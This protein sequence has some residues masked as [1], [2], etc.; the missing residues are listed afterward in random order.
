MLGER[1]VDVLAWEDFGQRW[2]ADIV[3]ELKP[4]DTRVLTADYGHLPDLASRRLR[5]RR[6]LHLERH[7]SGRARAGRQLDCRRPPRSHLR[8]CHV[9]AVRAG[10]RLAQNRCRHVL[11][12]EGARRGSGA[13]HDRPVAARLR[14]SRKVIDRAGRCPSSSVSPRTAACSTTFSPGHHQHAVVAV[15][16]GLPRCAALGRSDRRPHGVAGARRRQRRGAVRLDRATPWIANLAVDPG[17]ALQYLRVPALHRRAGRG[18]RSTPHRRSHGRPA[19]RRGGRPRPRRL[20]HGAAGAARSGAA[21]RSKKATCKRS[22]R[23]SIGPM[24]RPAPA[25]INA[26]RRSAGS[27]VPSRH[28]SDVNRPHSSRPGRPSAAG[29][30]KLGWAAPCALSSRLI[31]SCFWPSSPATRWPTRSPSPRASRRSPFSRPAP[32][33]RAP[34]VCRSEGRAHARVQRS[35][36]RGRARLHPRRRQGDRR[37]RHPIGRHAPPLH[38]ARRSGDAAGRAQGYRGRD[39]EAARRAR[40]RPG[41]GG[42]GAD[43]EDA[44]AEPRADA[45]PRPCPRTASR[46][47]RAPAVPHTDWHANPVADRLGHG[48]RRSARPSTPR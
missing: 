44:A 16:R 46:R 33:R 38:P 47:N 31:G 2:V 21:P 39:R 27:P 41:P 36:G 17:D 1:G 7:G 20:P 26:P 45:R 11:L 10:R 28:N 23:G 32:K 13:R 30:I 22:R 42:R 5:S 8:R 12:A 34:R 6:R 4:A 35:A 15:R 14:A 29:K 9:G 37:P 19:C 40:H 43:A 48:P 18:C 3:G 24:H 25:P